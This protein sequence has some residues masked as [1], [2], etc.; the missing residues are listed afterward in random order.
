[1]PDQYRLPAHKTDPSLLVLRRS[2]FHHAVPHGH[3]RSPGRRFKKAVGRTACPYYSLGHCPVL[4]RSNVCAVLCPFLGFH[5]QNGGIVCVAAYR[6]ARHGS[7]PGGLQRY[8]LLPHQTEL[9][10]ENS[11]RTV[12]EISAVSRCSQLRI[13]DHF[14]AR[15]HINLLAMGI[16]RI[17]SVFL[18]Y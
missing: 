8:I 4:R 15:L 16:Y 9:N 7:V 13:S 18:P 17:Q 10:A 5:G 3:R 12:S 2:L 1:M 11:R 6:K 14:I